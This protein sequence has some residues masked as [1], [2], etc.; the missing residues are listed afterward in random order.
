[1]IK[2]PTKSSS[3][4]LTATST[5]RYLWEQGSRDWLQRA[6]GDPNL[7]TPQWLETGDGF[8]SKK[9]SMGRSLS[10]CKYSQRELSVLEQYT[11]PSLY[12]LIFVSVPCWL[13]SIPNTSEYQKTIITRDACPMKL[14]ELPFDSHWLYLN[15]SHISLNGSLCSPPE[16]WP[17]FAA[18]P[19]S[20][21]PS[22]CSNIGTLRIIYRLTVSPEEDG[23]C[24]LGRSQRL[25]L[26]HN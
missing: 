25:A 1:M 3:P 9:A 14:T 6:F 11:H 20:R 22:I 5:G 17:C 21:K 18:R 2:D 12:N 15:I 13:E 26:Y 16:Y 8:F 23:A 7:T 4:I 19:T 24:S 10:S